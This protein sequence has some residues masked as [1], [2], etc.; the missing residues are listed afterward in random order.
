MDYFNSLASME[1]NAFILYVMYEG[2]P[3]SGAILLYN[4]RYMHYHLAGSNAGYRKY[5][6]NNLLLYDAACWAGRQGIRQVMAN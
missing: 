3:V 6:P 2:H 5:A 1:R 4:D